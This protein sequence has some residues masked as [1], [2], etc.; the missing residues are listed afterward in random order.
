V[1]TVVDSNVIVALWDH[2]D[3]LSAAAQAALDSV[4][5]RGGLVVPAPVFSELMALPGRTESFLDAFFQGTG[6]M[7]D[8]S[9]DERVWRAA[10]RAFQSYVGRRRKQRGPGPRRI[11]ADFLIGAYA[12]S[13]GFAL[14]TLDEGL[15]RA[16]FPGLK[17]LNLELRSK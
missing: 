10:G 3:A 2:D 9:L 15:Y 16:G 17:I 13:N 6:V 11:L 1:T 5:D 8:W 7:V 4:F 14:L 12:A